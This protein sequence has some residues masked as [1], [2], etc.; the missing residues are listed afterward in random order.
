MV[1]PLLFYSLLVAKTS[2]EF[3]SHNVFSF[4][5]AVSSFSASHSNA[6]KKT[7][8]F[9]IKEVEKG[10]NTTQNITKLMFAAMLLRQSEFA[11]CLL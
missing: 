6:V 10:K 9:G 1:R 11:H 3:S 4:F 5:P 8:K 7:Q 2:F